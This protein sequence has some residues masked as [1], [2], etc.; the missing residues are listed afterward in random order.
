MGSDTQATRLL[1]LGGT[2]EARKLA[3]RLSS[4]RRW[5]VISSLAG[6][7]REPEALAGQ[8]RVGGFGGVSGLE[9]YIAQHD[10]ELIVDATHPFAEAISH[11]AHVAAG[12]RNIRYLRLCR[13]AWQPGTGDCWL[14]AR[15]VEQAAKM[16]KPR[17][18]VLLT[19]GRQELGPFLQR[20]DI[21]I[22]A[23]TIEEPQEP[24]PAHAELILARPPFSVDNELALLRGREIDVLVTKNAGGT[25][26]E[27]KLT[28]AR[29]LGVA[30][31]MIE[32]PEDAPA[33]DA[34]SVDD[35]MQLLDLHYAT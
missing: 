2:R 34:Q 25:S 12:K 20:S 4:D 1:L 9:T 14:A 15:D 11:N 19:I 13:P 23:R 17:C 6:R 30:V 5:A 10:I 21:R 24:V 29:Q 8:V 32:R 22:V 7:T 27:A 16:I 28:A 18:K 35:L 3:E 33:V 26:V 31:I